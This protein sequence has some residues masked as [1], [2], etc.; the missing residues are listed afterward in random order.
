MSL[1]SYKSRLVTPDEALPG[2]DHLIFPVP[3]THAVHALAPVL[4]S[5]YLPA[6]HDVHTSDVDA[7]A[8]VP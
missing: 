2:R 8:G 5:L 6:E 4:S 3:A 1:S 7:A